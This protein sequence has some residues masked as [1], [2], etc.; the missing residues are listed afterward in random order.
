MADDRSVTW[1]DLTVP[2]AE[3]LRDFYEAVA[4]W[5]PAPVEMDGYADYNM[6][7]PATGT[8]VAG[9]CHA[10]GPNVDMPPVWIVYF[11]VHDLDAALEACRREGGDVMTPVRGAAG[12]RYALIR[13]PAGAVCALGEA[14]GQ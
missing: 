9:V 10:R 13:D 11:R 5:R 2:D 4:G 12:Y 1:V 8:P 14:R 7:E 3:G 6:I